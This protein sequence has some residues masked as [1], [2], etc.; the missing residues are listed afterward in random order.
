M[1]A[2]Q[3][4]AYFLSQ[5]KAN[6][7]A[8]AESNN[9]Q[10]L[11]QLQA[12]L[13]DIQNKAIKVNATSEVNFSPYFNNNGSLVSVTN[14]PNQNATGYDVNVTNGGLYSAQLNIS[15]NLLNDRAVK[16]LQFQ[17]SLQIG[18]N[19]LTY[20]LIYHNLEKNISDNYVLAYQLQSQKEFLFNEIIEI[21][22][23]VAIVELLTKNGLSQESDYL[24]VQLDLKAKKLELQQ[25]EA[26]LKSA[27]NQLF[28]L[29]N[30]EATDTSV[31]IKPNIVI[32]SNKN[33][34]FIH[35]KFNNDSLQ[36]E[37]NRLVFNNQYKPQ[38]N[39]YANTGV[40]STDITRINHHVGI[41]GGVRLTIPIYDGGQKNI[42]SQQQQL[43]QENLAT[44]RERNKTQLNNNLE[45][46]QIQIAYTQNNMIAIN[47]QLTIQSKIIEVY[48]TKLASGQVSILDFLNVS[49]D[50]RLAQFLKIQTQTNLWLL[51]NQFNYTNW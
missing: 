46:L 50:Y 11:V 35:Q 8:L 32:D 3:S 7:P 38:L 23:R 51:Y 43:Y 29:S 28:S 10:S 45:M 31:L 1:L 47:E 6:N 13:I 41:S 22:K 42:Y 40:N 26:N 49:R 21:K 33:L 14:L 34:L 12:K 18:S 20:E 48:K 36:L 27:I 25:I 16:N 37:A 15:K 30:L 9:A 5:A 17:N 4:L 39:M 19:K 44:Y 24:L 2:Q